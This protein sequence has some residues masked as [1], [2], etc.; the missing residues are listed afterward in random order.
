MPIL[1]IPWV[2]EEVLNANDRVM[3]VVQYEYFLLA[4]AGRRQ[5]VFPL[6]FGGTYPLLDNIQVT[7][8]PANHS[9][10][11]GEEEGFKPVGLPAGFIIR[12]ENGFTIYISGDT[13]FM[14]EMKTLIGDFYKPD[15]AVLSIAGIFT[16]GPVEGA[17]AAN[18]IGAKHNIPCHWFPQVANAADPEGMK[19]LIEA[20]PPINFMMDKNK[21]FSRELERYPGI[22]SLLLNPGESYKS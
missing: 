20:F 10:S 18:L 9:S 21:E 6:N 2:L 11:F 8:V 4:F 16:M 15:L 1:T 12:L 17:Y 22:E 3:G 14:S 13:G 5:N 19:K 7:L